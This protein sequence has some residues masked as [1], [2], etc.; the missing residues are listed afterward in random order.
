L[1]GTW[2][3]VFSQ[4]KKK[5]EESSNLFFSSKFLITIIPIIARKH[6]QARK[7]KKHTQIRKSKQYSWVGMWKKIKTRLDRIQHS[8]EKTDLFVERKEK[9]KDL[10]R[11]RLMSRSESRVCV[12]GGKGR[13]SMSSGRPDCLGGKR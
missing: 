8:T 13:F 6:G 12:G 3:L 2:G 7:K 1:Y 11:T 9:K 4:S 5:T 10:Q